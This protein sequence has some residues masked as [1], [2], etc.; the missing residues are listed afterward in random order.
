MKETTKTNKDM[1][2]LKNR[3]SIFV[4]STYEGNKSAKFMQYRETKRAAAYFANYFGGS[5]KQAATGYYI[6]DTKGL[7]QEKQNI[8]YS[9]C[10]DTQLQAHKDKIIAYAKRLKNRMKQEAITIT[11]NNEM[12]FI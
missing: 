10:S 7:I 5:T 6:S 12:I 11:I 3:I 9:N 2:T 4:P 8:I 1:E